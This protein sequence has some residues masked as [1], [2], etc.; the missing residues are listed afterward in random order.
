MHLNLKKMGLEARKAIKGVKNGSIM[1]LV[2]NHDLTPM[3]Y[4][5]KIKL[6]NDK[7]I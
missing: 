4:N 1:M 7:K 3:M 2:E 5:I 6:A